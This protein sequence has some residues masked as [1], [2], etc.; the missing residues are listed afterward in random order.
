[1]RLRCG[2]MSS[3]IFFIFSI[4]FCA[5]ETINAISVSVS[6]SRRFCRFARSE[7]FKFCWPSS[8]CTCVVSAA[9]CFLTLSCIL[10]A[11]ALSIDTTIALPTNPRPRKCFTMSCATVSSR[12]SRVIKLYCLP[13]TFSS[14][15]SCSSSVRLY[16]DPQI[17][18]TR[19]TH[20]SRGRDRTDR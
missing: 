2:S 9:Q 14:F 5:G 8:F 16:I 12:S 4:S 20:R 18:V 10:R 17:S 6:T 15:S 1:M 11:V 7:E 3:P 19:D 13:N